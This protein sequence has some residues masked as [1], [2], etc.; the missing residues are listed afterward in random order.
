MTTEQKL[1][2]EFEQRMDWLRKATPNSVS[3][4]SWQMLKKID[5]W[6]NEVGGEAAELWAGVEGKYW[7]SQAINKES[8]RIGRSRAPQRRRYR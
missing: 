6:C 3:A 8:N 5:E 1:D 2:A 4:Q 7:M